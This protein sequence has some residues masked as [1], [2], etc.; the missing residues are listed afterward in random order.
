VLGENKQSYFSDSKIVYLA[1]Q[2][3]ETATKLANLQKQKAQDSAKSKLVL[4]IKMRNGVDHRVELPV[5]EM[6]NIISLSV[7]PGM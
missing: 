2:G 5:G 3:K 4:K 1:H 7:E 6:K